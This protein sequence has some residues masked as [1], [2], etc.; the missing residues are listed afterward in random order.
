MLANLLGSLLFMAILGIGDAAVLMGLSR[1]GV[2]RARVEGTATS[3]DLRRLFPI[4]VGLSLVA[5]AVVGWF[6]GPIVFEAAGLT[7]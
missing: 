3:V 7:L 6:A 2:Q 5:G 1:A 4:I